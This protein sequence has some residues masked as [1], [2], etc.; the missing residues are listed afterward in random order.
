MDEHTVLLSG[1]EVAVAMLATAEYIQNIEAIDSL[2]QRT[3]TLKRSQT[4]RTAELERARA[5]FQKLQKE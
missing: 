5:L 2:A 4:Q 3:G 1:E